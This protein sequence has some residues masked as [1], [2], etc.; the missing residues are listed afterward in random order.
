MYD[1]ATMARIFV[2]RE[3][4]GAPDRKLGKIVAK[5]L[6]RDRVAWEIYIQGGGARKG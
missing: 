6:L 1:V 2:N 5:A 4:G 3:I